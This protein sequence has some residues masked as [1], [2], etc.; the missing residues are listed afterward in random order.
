MFAKDFDASDFINNQPVAFGYNFSYLQAVAP[1]F[2]VGPKRAVRP[3]FS[4][5]CGL[6][7]T[8]S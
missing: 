4:L 3:S 6:L 5:F 7:I 1:D 8:E 2:E